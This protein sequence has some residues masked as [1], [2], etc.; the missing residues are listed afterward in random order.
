MLPPT[1]MITGAEAMPP[2]APAVHLL[3]ECRVQP[4]LGVLPAAALP[5]LPGE[6]AEGRPLARRRGPR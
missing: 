6:A 3:E 4:T 1:T 2:S 5:C